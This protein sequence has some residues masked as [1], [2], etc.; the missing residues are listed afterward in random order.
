MGIIMCRISKHNDHGS[1]HLPIETILNLKPNLHMKPLQAYNFEKTNWD[2][3]KAE[4]KQQ[5]PPINLTQPRAPSP[6]SVDQLATSITKAIT[7]AVQA[8]AQKEKL[9]IQNSPQ[10]PFVRRRLTGVW[11]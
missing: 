6:D 3:L 8:S 2:V 4:L 5:L 9:T 7:K 10:T 1:D 11:W